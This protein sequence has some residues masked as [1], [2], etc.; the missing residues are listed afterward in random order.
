MS[1]ADSLCH[2]WYGWYID[3]PVA[4][5]YLLCVKHLDPIVD[6]P[7]RHQIRCCVR[8]TPDLGTRMVISSWYTLV[9]SQ[10]FFYTLS[11][12]AA[13]AFCCIEGPSH[14]LCARG[15]GFSGASVLVI[16]HFMP[17]GL[18]TPF[19]PDGSVSIDKS[20]ISRKIAGK[21]YDVWQGLH[22]FPRSSPSKG[23]KPCT[24]H[25]RFAHWAWFR[26]LL[27]LGLG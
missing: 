20:S 13:Q 19:A 15:V 5:D 21:Q 9:S 25:L 6:M 4:R 3:T 27:P 1:F 7:S 2:W 18:P 17:L 26:A 8:L 12:L 14:F 16:K 23:A 11:H 24:Y 22:A 10:P